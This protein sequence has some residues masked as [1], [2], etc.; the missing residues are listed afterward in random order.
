M[1]EG[2]DLVDGRRVATARTHEEDGLQEA[3]F[4]E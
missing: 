2:V 4:A 3:L 1:L